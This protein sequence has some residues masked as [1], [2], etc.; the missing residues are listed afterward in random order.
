MEDSTYFYRNVTFSKVAEKIYL[1]DIFNPDDDPE[2]LEGWLGMVLLLADGQHTIAELVTYLATRY[3]GSPPPNL[4]DTIESVVK[5]MSENKFIM[6]TD[7]KTDL[8][9]YLSLPYE[10]LDIEKA[11]KMMTED[12]RDIN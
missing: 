10:R 12:R 1:I 5:R 6:L 8:P 4:K 11:K 7:I 9:Y 3:T 2:E